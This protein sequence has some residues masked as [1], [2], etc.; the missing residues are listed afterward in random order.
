MEN[1][2]S[3]DFGLIQPSIWNS[4][5]SK[6]NLLMSFNCIVRTHGLVIL[7]LLAATETLAADKP[8][9]KPEKLAIWPNDSAPIGAGNFEKE[10][11]FITVHRPAADKANGAALVICPGGGYQRLVVDAEGHGIAQ[12]LVAHGITGIVLEYRMPRGRSSVPLLDAQRALRTA[13]ARAGEWKIDPKRI[14]IIGF[15]AGGHLASTAGTH[16]D[17]GKSDAA[18]PIERVSS[19]PD[20]MVLVYPVI[21]MSDIGNAG[22]RTNL[23][24]REPKPD[25]LEL[26]SNEKQVTDRTPPAFLAH[27]VDDKPVP[28]ANSRIFN[29][30][31]KAHH[32]AA[33]YLELPEGGHGLNGLK[34]PMWEAWK[35]KSL[36]WLAAQKMIPAADAGNPAKS[37][38]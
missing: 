1:C 6:G 8:G 36:L 32:V 21:T 14:G 16:F 30:A 13:R 17:D 2:F 5:Q 10:N 33:E 25:L 38:K 24:G 12:W 20:F 18:D 15:S 28:P 31:L 29:D 7:L 27:A 4:W 9:P 22:T 26:F 3:A 35:T 37:P 19:R 34:G 23:L 11:T